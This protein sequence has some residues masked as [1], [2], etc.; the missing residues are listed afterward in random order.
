MRKLLL[1][2]LIVLCTVFIL[3][4]PLDISADSTAD[5]TIEA[6][7]SDIC[8][9]TAQL[10]TK[11]EN[12]VRILTYN[13][14]SDGIGFEGSP[15]EGRKA[16]VLEVLSALSPDVVC[17]QEVSRGWFT[18]LKNDSSLTAV[19]PLETEI[20]GLMTVILFD[21]ETVELKN[22]GNEVY[23]TGGDY[24]MRRAVWGLFRRKESG[25]TFCVVN[26]HFNI[27]KNY[28]SYSSIQAMEL[29]EITDDL[30]NQYSCPIFVTG[31]FNAKKRTTVSYPASSVYE[32][33]ASHFSD[34]SLTCKSFSTGNTGISRNSTV[35]H[36][37]TVGDLKIYRYVILSQKVFLHLSDHYPIFVDA[38]L[39]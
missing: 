30:R 31:D 3:A 21:P 37:F 8:R 23:N 35:D 19:N 22:H 26:T 33:L 17:L 4:V 24:R 14:L 32:I 16:G 36:I 20:A 2:A 38:Q 6:Q 25:E 29:I 7:I 27:T 10:H 12:T 11:D 13:V 1:R 28:N 18:V 9:R 15:C 5:T 39:N 34:G